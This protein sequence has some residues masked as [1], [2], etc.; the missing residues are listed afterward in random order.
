[1]ADRGC[2]FRLFQGRRKKDSAKLGAAASRG[3]RREASALPSGVRGEKKRFRL[4]LAYRRRKEKKKKEN[5]ARNSKGGRA[6][7]S[8]E[9]K[10]KRTGE[11]PSIIA[12]DIIE[13][14]RA[15][16][17]RSR[18]GKKKKGKESRNLKKSRN[19]E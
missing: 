1:V 2:V 9:K 13:K 8:L 18:P 16:K 17:P 11:S 5:F 19:A 10:K 3:E 14:K 4:R 6:C 15:L 7:G 12:S